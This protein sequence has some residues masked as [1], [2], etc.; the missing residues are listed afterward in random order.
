MRSPLT[1][2]LVPSLFL[3]LGA[4]IT[5]QSPA[6][7]AQ[8]TP[9]FEVAT[10]RINNS[11]DLQS[12]FNAPPGTG[13]VTIVNMML[14]G[15]IQTAYQLHPY[16]LVN[17]PDWVQTTRIDIVAKADRSASAAELREMLKPLL[18]DRFGLEVHREQRE[19]DVLALVLAREDGALGPNLTRSKADCGADI[20]TPRD[21]LPAPQPDAP[22]CGLRP[23]GPGR[24]LASGFDL[25]GFSAILGVALGRPVV[26]QTGL[27]GG[28]DIDVRYT[29][30]PFA[31]AALALR[32]GA[33]APE[34]IDPEGP[35][36]YA[37]LEDQLGLKLQP[38]RAPVDVL[39]IDH[40]EPLRPD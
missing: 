19:M 38:A 10:V 17:I 2:A 9:Q 40:V 24:F 20:D 36:L 21:Q 13:N 32:P 33:A 37:A 27:A 14:R 6:A 18:A 22:Q 3:G 30:E 4:S 28:Y 34:G 1:L 7:S 25:R 26:D 11:G 35:S 39:V 8:E 15:T 16:Q 23:G 5:A 29:P 12:R 31:A